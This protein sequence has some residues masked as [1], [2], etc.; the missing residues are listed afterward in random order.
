MCV[1]GSEKIIFLV[2]T[3][4]R[5]F[6]GSHKN[7]F[8]GLFNVKRGYFSGVFSAIWSA[9]YCFTARIQLCT[10]DEHQTC[11]LETNER[12]ACFYPL[13]YVIHC[14]YLQSSKDQVAVLSCVTLI[15]TYFV[16]TRGCSGKKS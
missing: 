11:K 10:I 13:K 3:L 5:I 9:N 8:G 15:L 7:L 6:W 1:G 12:L 16:L 2:E 14:K 4:L